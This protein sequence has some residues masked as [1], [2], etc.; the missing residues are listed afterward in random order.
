MEKDKILQAM[1]KWYHE[2]AYTHNYCFGF[3]RN[4]VVYAALVKGVTAETL[5]KVSTLTKASSKNGGGYAMRYKVNA[6]IWDF[7]TAIADTVITLCSEEYLENLYNNSVYNRGQLFEKLTAER[8]GAKLDEK[9]NTSF[10]DGGDF[11]LNGV[12][13]QVK[14]MKATFTNEATMNNMGGIK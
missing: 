11:Y 10:K 6:K 9:A 14:Y 4:G 7:I 5:V 8:F 3:K 1:A 13:Y 2:N 12:P